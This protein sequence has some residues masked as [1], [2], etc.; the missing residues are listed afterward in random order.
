MKAIVQDVYGSADVLQLRE[1]E[2]PAV[3]EHD[4]LFAVEAAGVDR[5]VWHTMTGRPTMARLFLGLR[6]PKVRVRGGEAA[7][8]VVEVGSAVTRFAVGDAGVRHRAGHLRRV[9]GRERGPSRA[10]SGERHGRAGGVAADLGCGGVVRGR[11]REDPP[12]HRVLVLGASGG[13][14]VFAVQLAKAAGAHVTGV[15]STAKLDLVRSIGADEVLDYTAGDV[16][17][18]SVAV[19][20]DHRRRRQ[21]AAGAAC[22]GHSSAAARW[23]SSAARTAAAR[24]SAGSSGRCS[25]ASSRRS[26]R[27]AW[28][29]SCRTRARCRSRRCA[30]P[31]RRACWCRRSSASSRSPRRRMRSALS[32]PGAIRGKVVVR[33]AKS[34]ASATRATLRQLAEK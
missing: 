5:S 22:G 6:A 9:R 19:R 32:R 28:P 15:A 10:P 8:T 31:P 14:G 12:G 34:P 2:R 25:P 4:V 24:C 16:L 33:V 29:A 26:C 13:V 1:I 23:R 20:R 3:G 7:G 27:S 18:G 11:G 17:D 21:P 30:R